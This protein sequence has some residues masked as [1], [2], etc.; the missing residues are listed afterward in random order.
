[1]SKDVVSGGPLLEAKDLF[2]SY[3]MGESQVN[4]LCGL[5]LQIYDG[6]AL[7]IMGSSGTGKSTLLHLLGTLDQPTKGHIFYK[8]KDLS[9]R[10]PEELA[11]FRNQN[12]G[13]VFQFHHLLKE[14]TVLENVMLPAQI[15]GTSK[16]VARVRA[17]YL[18]KD[19]GV[20]HRQHHFPREISGGEAQRV[21]IARALMQS[22]DILFA[23]EPTGNLDSK[24][25]KHIED[26]FFDLHK[27]KKLTL[28]VVTHNQEFS[29]RFSR[30]LRLQE[31]QLTA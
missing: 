9:N 14:F 31:G 7:C 20:D 11:H 26:I 28:I 8:G 24:N 13:F 2:K 15:A 6:E 5:N 29:Q 3:E 1:M 19:L 21:A 22:P 30:I 16:K 23:D 4:V 25:A 18:L 17:L 10:S 12:M 27:S